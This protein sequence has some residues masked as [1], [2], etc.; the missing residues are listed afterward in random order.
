MLGLA[1]ATAANEES[2]AKATSN[3]MDLRIISKY[4][5]F[6]GHYTHLGNPYPVQKVTAPVRPWLA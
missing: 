1:T 3:D 5:Y 2:V 6:S 4:P